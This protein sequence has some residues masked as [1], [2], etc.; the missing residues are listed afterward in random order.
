MEDQW[1]IDGSH[2]DRQESAWKATVNLGL[3]EI[4]VD[5]F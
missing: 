4:L 1:S 3:G 2:R 5:S